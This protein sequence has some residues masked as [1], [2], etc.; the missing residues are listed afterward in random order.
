MAWVTWIGE[1]GADGPD[2]PGPSFTTWRG[3][4]FPKGEPVEVNDPE[5]I[6]KA[7]GNKF[8]AVEIEPKADKPKRGRSPKVKDGDD[9]NPE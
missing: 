4:K 7:L 6:R 8:F 5:M 1:D 3:V 9:Q 2:I